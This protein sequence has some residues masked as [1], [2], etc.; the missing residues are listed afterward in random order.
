MTDFNLA[1]HC[2][3]PRDA[4]SLY[5]GFGP[6]AEL[7]RSMPGLRLCSLP[8]EITWNTLAQCDAIFLQRPFRPNDLDLA[9]MACRLRLPIWV[10]LDDDLFS[11]PSWNPSSPLYNRP[12]VAQCI[13]DV[14][15]I[16]TVVSASTRHLADELQSHTQA[17]V[18][19]VP[20]AINMRVFRRELPERIEDP[21]ERLIVWRGS[22]TH[23]K[24]LNI[25]AEAC[26]AVAKENPNVTWLFIG[27]APWFVDYMPPR[28]VRTAP[29]IDP[30]EYHDCIRQLRPNIWIVPLVDIPFNRSKSN[31]AWLEASFAG[32][33]SLVPAWDEWRV[34]GVV[35]YGSEAD[36]AVKLRS[37]VAESTST[38]DALADK[39]WQY[40][41]SNLTLGLANQKRQ[42]ILEG[43]RR[44]AREPTNPI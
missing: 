3:N 32:A 2:P 30:F 14:L 1:V 10:D 21:R 17:S 24:D 13:H 16:A 8:P 34:P 5:R 20:N 44:E 7:R 42:A 25:A 41:S 22:P 15:E 9:R 12:G 27:D 36:F 37:M 18:V 38:L 43:L 4:T 28:L 19:V 35:N 26:I 39:S 23:R 33:A 31:C 40:I 6:L 11:V 29:A